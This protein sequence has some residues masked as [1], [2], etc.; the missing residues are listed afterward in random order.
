MRIDLQVRDVDYN[1]TVLAWNVEIDAKENINLFGYIVEISESPNGPY[2]PLFSQ[3]IYHAYGYVDRETQRGM[4]D[5]RLYYRIK[6]IYVTGKEFYS[7]PITLFDEHPNYLSRAI[8]RYESLLLRRYN[9]QEALHFARRKF[10]PRCSNCYSDI[11]R[12]VIKSKCPYC[13]G[14][15]YQDGFFA[16]VKIKINPDPQTKI[17]DRHE[18]GVNENFNL[19]GWTSND[20]V[21]EALDIII[22]L[23]KNSER[24]RVEAVTPT[25]IKNATVRQILTFTRLP[26]DSPEQQL[27]ADTESYNLDEFNVFRRDWRQFK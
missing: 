24:Y 7:D 10:G 6:A 3:P 17:A 13:F 12:K 23:Q 26:L 25:S 21:I 22:F 14:T 9:G 2:I 18:Y 8:S 4:V 20:V 15:T 27:L 11:D 5:Q 19:S 1:K 16:P